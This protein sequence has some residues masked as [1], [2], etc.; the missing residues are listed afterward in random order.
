MKKTC[1][2]PYASNVSMP[3]ANEKIDAPSP[4]KSQLSGLSRGASRV[5]RKS[6]RTD[7]TNNQIQRPNPM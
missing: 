4:R 6:V 5:R 3:I 7:L 2:Y 1:V